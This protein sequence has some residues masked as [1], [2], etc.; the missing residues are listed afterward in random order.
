L[1]PENNLFRADKQLDA[2]RKQKGHSYEWPFAFSVI[3]ADK[4]SNSDLEELKLLA[5]LKRLNKP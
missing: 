4:I 1:L 5:G 3:P 2:A